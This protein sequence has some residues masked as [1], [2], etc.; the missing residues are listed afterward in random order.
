MYSLRHS[1]VAVALLALVSF[2]AIGC[3]ASAH[4]SAGGA[5]PHVKDA[6]LSKSKG[7]E[8]SNLSCEPANVATVAEVAPGVVSSALSALSPAP[9]VVVA[10]SGVGSIAFFHS[11]FTPS[12]STAAAV[13]TGAYQIVP[14]DPSLQSC[15]IL[16][17]DRPAAQPFITTAVN[18]AVSDGMAGSATSLRA[19]LSGIE[20]GDNPLAAGSLV[21]VL[22]VSGPPQGTVAGHTVE[23]PASSI[24]VIID[25]ATGAVT[26][27]SQGTW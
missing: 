7:D 2:G 6:G 10:D 8:I 13:F 5:L 19:N 14:D 1:G 15:D 20:I 23:G 26:G 25:Q 22:V 27:I 12:G 16:L 4:P 11:G 24:F 3:S 9:L 17:A 21:V 18:T